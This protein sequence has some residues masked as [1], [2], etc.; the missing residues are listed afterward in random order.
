MD[1]KRSFKRINYREPVLY[2]L[3][4]DQPDI[5]CVGYDISAGGIRCTVNDFIPLGKEIQLTVHLTRDDLVALTGRVVWVKRLA[6][7]EN[8]QVGLRFVETNGIDPIKERLADYIE[9]SK[10]FS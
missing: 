6:H 8:Y 1:E 5:G 2:R 10:S 9:A 3:L 4:F 7:G